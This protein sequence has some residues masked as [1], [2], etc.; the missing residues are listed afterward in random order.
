MTGEMFDLLSTQSVLRHSV[1][2]LGDWDQDVFETSISD[3]ISHPAM[4]ATKL[5]QLRASDLLEGV[6]AAANRARMSGILI[7]MELAGA[8]PYWLGQEVALVGAPAL[9]DLYTTAL[10]AQGLET[11]QHSGDEMTLKG[12]TAAYQENIA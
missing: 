12:L 7:G 11:T 3:A 2:T 9:N 1:G 6:T 8:K 4:M 10:I 5:F